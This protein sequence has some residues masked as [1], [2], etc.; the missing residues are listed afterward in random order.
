MADAKGV[1]K[2]RK[3]KDVKKYQKNIIPVLLS[4]S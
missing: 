4:I 1:K 3:R 2:A